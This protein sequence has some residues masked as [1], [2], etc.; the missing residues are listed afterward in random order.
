M[1]KLLMGIAW[2]ASLLTVYEFFYW[3]NNEGSDLPLLFIFIFFSIVV[4]AMASVQER[5]KKD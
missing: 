3:I 4:I 1:K 5:T 2:V